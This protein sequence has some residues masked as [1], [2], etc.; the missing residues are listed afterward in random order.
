MRAQW[1]CSRER[2]ITLYKRSSIINIYI[3]VMFCVWGETDIKWEKGKRRAQGL[4]IALR[5]LSVSCR[6]AVLTLSL[7][8]NRFKANFGETSE[9]RDGAYN[10]G[11]SERIIWAFRSAY[12]PS[13]TELNW[14]R[15][16]W[17]SV[18]PFYLRDSSRYL[19]R[20]Q[21]NKT[22]QP[23]ADRYPTSHFHRLTVL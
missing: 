9:R 13:W 23:K 14:T 20:K 5:C 11:F 4:C 22:I 1:V 12:I 15:R 3:Y 19:T 21:R 16:Q 2:R 18:P 8:W 17:Q 7:H 10:M 6:L